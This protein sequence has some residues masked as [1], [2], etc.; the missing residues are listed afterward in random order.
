MAI[1]IGAVQAIVS[2]V[3]ALIRSKALVAPLAVFRGFAGWVVLALEFMLAAD[4]FAN[5]P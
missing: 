5:R 4:I 3:A 1:V 2:T